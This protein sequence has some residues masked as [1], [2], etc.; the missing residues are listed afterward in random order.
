MQKNAKNGMFFYKECKRM[1]RTERTFEKNGC[2]TLT[3]SD[4]LGNPRPGEFVLLLVILSCYWF[5]CME[6]TK[7]NKYSAQQVD[8]LYTQSNKHFMSEDKTKQSWL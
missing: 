5:A 6:N 2:P 1:Q 4:K 7:E 3:L 8:L